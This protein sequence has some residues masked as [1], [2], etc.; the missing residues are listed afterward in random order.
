MKRKTGI[1]RR[2]E[3]KKGERVE[4]EGVEGVKMNWSVEERRTGEVKAREGRG[5]EKKGI[6]VRRRE[7][8]RRREKKGQ[9]K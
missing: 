4:T 9:I 1:E 3:V 8:G 5:E 6:K 7:D 2:R